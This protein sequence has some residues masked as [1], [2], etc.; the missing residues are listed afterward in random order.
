MLF[1]VRDTYVFAAVQSQGISLFYY[2]HMVE[3][4]SGIPQS[5]LTVSGQDRRVWPAG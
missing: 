5:F 2:A 3:P 4:H 1:H